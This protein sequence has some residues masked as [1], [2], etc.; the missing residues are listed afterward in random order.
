MLTLITVFFLLKDLHHLCG[1]YRIGY[2]FYHPLIAALEGVLL[3]K[4][5]A[6]QITLIERGDFLSIRLPVL[7]GVASTGARFSAAFLLLLVRILPVG[8]FFPFRLLRRGLIGF[9][10]DLFDAL[11]LDRFPEFGVLL[12]EGLLL[13]FY[14][15]VGGSQLNNTLDQLRLWEIPKDALISL[16]DI[17]ELH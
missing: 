17:L 10:V 2:V 13:R 11:L 8:F 12:A 3:A 14:L 16:Q 1:L 9:A 7:C 5:F 4:I 6:A 15:G